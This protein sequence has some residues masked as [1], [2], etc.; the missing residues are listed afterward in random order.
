MC[1][2]GGGGWRVGG[3]RSLRQSNETLGG[4]PHRRTRLWGTVHVDIAVANRLGSMGCRQLPTG[5]VVWSSCGSGA[6]WEAVWRTTVYLSFQLLSKTIVIRQRFHGVLKKK[7]AA[8]KFVPRTEETGIRAN[9]QN[10]L[11]MSVFHNRTPSSLSIARSSS[12]PTCWKSR[13]VP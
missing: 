7:A 12:L 2:W 5:T 11:V 9:G 1:V 3:V 13:P 4:R 6:L 10:K 8:C